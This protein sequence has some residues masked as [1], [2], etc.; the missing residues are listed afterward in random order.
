[1]NI[2]ELAKLAP[3]ELR[4]ELAG[5]RREQFSLRMQHVTGQLTE[6]H[7]LKALRCSIARVK[8]VLTQKLSVG[9]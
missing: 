5:L 8:T 2:E 7:K 9:V 6:T 3:Q 4:K 1:M